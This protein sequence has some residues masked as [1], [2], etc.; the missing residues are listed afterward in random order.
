[1]KKQVI[2][3]EATTEKN[4]LVAYRTNNDLRR[5]SIIKISYSG[6]N[7]GKV[8]C[9]NPSMTVMSTMDIVISE[10]KLKEIKDVFFN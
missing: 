4:G 1:M 2:L 5:V 7:N 9:I 10:E 3:L 6:R 8:G